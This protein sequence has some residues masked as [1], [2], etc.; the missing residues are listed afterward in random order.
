M[1]WLSRV[2]CT[3]ALL[4]CA[5]AAFA[6]DDA[7]RGSLPV[8]PAMFPRWSGFYFGGDAGFGTASGDFSKTTAGPIAFVLRE[9]ALENDI[10]PSSWPVLGGGN[11]SRAMFGGFVG[12]NMQWQDLILSLEGDYRQASFS[13]N[14]SNNPISRVTPPDSGGNTYLVNLAGAGSV[15]DLNYGTLRARAGWIVGNFMPYGFF[16][17]AVGVANTSVS[18]TVSGIEYAAGSNSTCTVA[19]PCVPFSF[20]GTSGRTSQVLV[21]FSV[22]GGLEVALTRNIFVR[23]EYEFVQFAPVSGITL[24]IS[25]AHVGAGFKF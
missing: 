5:P 19:L 4:A 25:S 6:D 9:S 18:A 3:V 11:N 23:G 10:G 20:T 21:G 7:L 16:G 2:I 12:Y 8:G 14:A 15:D 22:G 24:D 17:L 1:R 13:V